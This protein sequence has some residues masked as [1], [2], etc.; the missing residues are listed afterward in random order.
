MCIGPSSPKSIIFFDLLSQCL[1]FIFDH[2]TRGQTLEK[3]DI[4][5]H[6]IQ[7]HK[8]NKHIGIRDDIGG[9]NYMKYKK[10][11]KSKYKIF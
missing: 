10:Y 9:Y 5:G 4:F 8:I 1:A 7:K 6:F 11:S 2:F 3:E